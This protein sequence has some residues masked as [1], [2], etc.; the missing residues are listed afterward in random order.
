MSGF[1]G[2]TNCPNCG[3]KCDEYTDNKPY[4]Y[5]VITCYNCGLRIEPIVNYID[6]DELNELREELGLD[7]INILPDQSFEG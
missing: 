7:I 5:T 3:Q 1:N 6:I 4:S 2:E